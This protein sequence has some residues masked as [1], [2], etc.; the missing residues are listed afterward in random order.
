MGGLGGENGR[1]CPKIQA[2]EEFIVTQCDCNGSVLD[3]AV[4]LASSHLQKS[5]L[6]WRHHPGK[7]RLC[8]RRHFCPSSEHTGMW[9]TEERGPHC[10]SLDEGTPARTAKPTGSTVTGSDIIGSVIP[11][12]VYVNCCK[13]KILNNKKNKHRWTDSSINK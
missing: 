4:F 10:Y 5:F 7:S 6:I 12:N 2:E 1:G 11:W 9:L 3:V 13:K 8:M